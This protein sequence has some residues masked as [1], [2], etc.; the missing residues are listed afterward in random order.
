MQYADWMVK[1]LFIVLKKNKKNAFKLKTI[2]PV[3]ISALLK[4]EK[5]IIVLQFTVKT[6]KASK[7]QVRQGAC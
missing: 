3:S 6:K 1:V 7:Q 4:K 5:M 2:F